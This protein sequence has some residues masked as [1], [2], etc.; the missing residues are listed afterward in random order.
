MKQ[1]T[2][3]DKQELS[4][5]QIRKDNL[6]VTDKQILGQGK[7]LYLVCWSRTA[8]FGYNLVRG[9]SESQII[10]DFLFSLNPYVNLIITQIDIKNMPV[11]SKAINGGVTE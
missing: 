5:R 2:S 4:V 7:N 8:N 3:K 9:D 11:I 1:T 6:Q 10:E